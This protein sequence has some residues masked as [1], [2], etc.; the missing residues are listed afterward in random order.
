MTKTTL[1]NIAAIGFL[2]IVFGFLFYLFFVYD[3][4][5]PTPKE[6]SAKV[7]LYT[8]PVT[9]ETRIV[10]AETGRGTFF[11]YY[12]GFGVTLENVE[13][14]PNGEWRITLKDHARP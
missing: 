1:K 6:F 12:D 2:A 4:E 9:G 3:Y 7:K 8:K 11:S 13:K 14:L 5:V 10:D